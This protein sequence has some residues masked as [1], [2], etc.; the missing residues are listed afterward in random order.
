MIK[1]MIVDDEPLIRMAIKNL[2]DWEENGFEITGEASNGETA[3]ALIEKDPPDIIMTDI[4]MPRMDGIEL[5]SH[6]REKFPQIVVV[7]LSSYNDYEYVREAFVYGAVDYILK[8]DLDN[9]N[10]AKVI[11]KLRDKYIADN[12]IKVDTLKKENQIKRDIE[13]LREEFLRRMVK[14]QFSDQADLEHALA[15]YELHLREGSYLMCN[16]VL[17]YVDTEASEA[18]LVAQRSTALDV[19]HE[20]FT[21]DGFYFNDSPNRYT[22]LLYMSSPSESQFMQDVYAFLNLLKNNLSR[23]LNVEVTAGLSKILS[24]QEKIPEA[25]RQ[26]WEA[27]RNHFYEGP[28]KTYHYSD[29]PQE[30][31]EEALRRFNERENIQRVKEYLSRKD[32]DSI[33]AYI[34]EFQA[35]LR[36]HRYEERKVKE[37]L[38]NFFLLV[39]SEMIGQISADN[40]LLYTNDKIYARIMGCSTLKELESFMNDYITHL[41]DYCRQMTRDRYSRPISE[42]IEYINRYFNQDITLT[43]ISE[44]INM[45][46][47]YLSRLFLQETGMHFIDYITNLRI[48]K[49]KIYLKQKDCTM[50]EIGEMVGYANPKYFSQIFKKIVGMSPGQY[51]NHG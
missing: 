6:V 21:F 46:P 29:L 18:D 44:K 40:A 7:V 37:L 30:E 41:K 45:N 19:L 17:D 35:F 38:I 5:I 42:T 47:S 28:G 2:F 14:G 20:I 3:L 50:Q 32:W 36:A 25:Y 9:D 49:A 11:C 43:T 8:S 48:E 23:Y 27:L 12:D 51:R 16:V 31:D 34:A 15:V 26:A 24:K 4:K 22:M 13:Y 1:L 10:F 39:Q 33:D